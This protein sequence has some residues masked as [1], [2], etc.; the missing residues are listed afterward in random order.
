MSLVPRAGVT[1]DRVAETAASIA[2]ESGLDALTLAA[3][4]GRLGVSV[5]S[6]YK[7]VDGLDG[8]RRLLCLRSIDELA[9]VVTGAVVGRSVGDALSSMCVA[10]REYARRHPGRYAATVTAPRPG[11]DQHERAASRVLHPVLALIAGYGLDEAQQIDAARVLR[12]SLHGFVTL[13]LQGGFGLPRSVDES[14]RQ[15]VAAL[16]RSLATWQSVGAPVASSDR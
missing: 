16:D 13:E 15:L 12:S 2:D 7:H 14:F 6:L 1:P 9:D 3:V 8:M 5:P 10:Y 11:D 4:A